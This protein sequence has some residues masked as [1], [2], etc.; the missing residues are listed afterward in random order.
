MP[1]NQSIIQKTDEYLLHNSAR[2]P[3]AVLRGEGAYVWDAN[4]KRYLDFMGGIAT[5]ALGHCH[6]VLVEVAK[7]QLERL[8]HVSNI[9]HTQPQVELAEKLVKVSG[10]SK[11]S[12]FF[13]NSGAEANETMLKLVRRAQKDK[14]HPERYEVISFESSFHGRTLATVA[15]TGQEKH[16]KGFE[17]L[18]AGF[19]HVPFGDIEAVEAAVSSQTAAILVEPI[20]CEGGVKPAPQGFLRALSQLCEKKGLFLLVDEVQTGMGRTG[21]W[22]GFQHDGILPSA[23]S[24]AKALSNGLPIGAMV[25]NAE[26]APSLPPGSHNST[27][28]GNPVATAV[29]SAVMDLLSEGHLFEEVARKEARLKQGLLKTQQ[30]FPKLIKEV[31]G[32]G[33]L[34]GIEFPFPVGPIIARCAEASLLVVSAGENV[35]RFMP[36]L[37]LTDEQMDEGIEIFEK[38]LSLL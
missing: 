9:F 3:I 36:S 4:G 28:G 6:P 34:L 21:K 16:K 12:V 14:G 29:G 2:Q 8:W 13:C 24:L 32:R 38:A 35:V 18:P 10:F 26:L 23:F 31:R 30:R 15:A 22:F 5:C 19:V 20:Q 25:C 7:R 11:A 27:F 33:L 37:L 1:D 17:P